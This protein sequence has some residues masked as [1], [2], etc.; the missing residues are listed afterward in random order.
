MTVRMK[1][2][3]SLLAIAIASGAAAL[4]AVG[5]LEWVGRWR[6]TW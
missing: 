2:S 5:P 3:A 6:A 4:R 1:H